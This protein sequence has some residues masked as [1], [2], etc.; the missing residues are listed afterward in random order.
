MSLRYSNDVSEDTDDPLTISD[1]FQPSDLE[2]LVIYN[3]GR[4]E[5]ETCSVLDPQPRQENIPDTQS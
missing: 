3:V 2:Q 4:E 1:L 5:Y